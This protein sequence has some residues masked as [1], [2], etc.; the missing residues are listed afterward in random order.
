MAEDSIG[1]AWPTA[2]KRKISIVGQV[3]HT[4][5]KS[6]VSESPIELSQS[7]E[8]GG[9]S[10]SLQGCPLSPLTRVALVIPDDWKRD[11]D[12]GFSDAMPSSDEEISEEEEG[13][14]PGGVLVDFL[15]RGCSIRKKRAGSQHSPTN[16]ARFN[17]QPSLQGRC[18]SRNL[19]DALA[20]HYSVAQKLIGQH[21]TL[22]PNDFHEA[23]ER[24]NYERLFST[25]MEDFIRF[26]KVNGAAEWKVNPRTLLRQRAFEIA[27]YLN[28]AKC[29]Y[30]EINQQLL[31]QSVRRFV[32]TNQTKENAQERYG[33]T[34]QVWSQLHEGARKVEVPAVK[35]PF[36]DDLRRRL[37]GEQDKGLR[38]KS[39]GSV[40]RCLSNIRSRP[41]SAAASDSG[42]CEM[43]KENSLLQDLDWKRRSCRSKASVGSWDWAHGSSLH[44]QK[45]SRH[46]RPA[47]LTQ[48][49]IPAKEEECQYNEH[50]SVSL[51]DADD[52]ELKKVAAD[53]EDTSLE[54]GPVGKIFLSQSIMSIAD[55]PANRDPS[56]S[57]TSWNSKINK[58]SSLPNLRSLSTTTAFSNHVL[59]GKQV[60]GKRPNS[61]SSSRREKHCSQLQ[62]PVASAVSVPW[63]SRSPAP[64]LRMEDT[65]CKQY[66]RACLQNNT[67]PRPYPFITGHSLKLNAA[68]HVLSDKDLLDMTVALEGMHLEDIDLSD[69]TSLTE[70]SLLKFLSALSDGPTSSSLLRLSLKR[71]SHASKYSVLTKIIDLV[72]DDAGVQN[73]QHLDLTHVLMGLRCHLPFAKAVRDHQHLTSLNL[74]N[75]G[76]G[77][78]QG[79][80]AKEF[81]YNLLGSQSVKVLDL[82]WNS[83]TQDFFSQIGERH[84]EMQKLRRLSLSNCTTAPARAQ[85]A[86]SIG[87]FLQHL[88]RDAVL[89]FLDISLNHIDFRSAL[90]LE[91]AVM[92]CKKLTEINVAHNPLGVVGM[93]SFLRLLC[94]D[95]S[96]LMS[97][98]CHD[99]SSGLTKDERDGLQ[100]FRASDPGGRYCLEL[101]RPYHRAMLRMLYKT[102]DMFAVPIAEAFS[103]IAY[104]LP[105]WVHGEKDD[106]GIWIVPT[107]GKLNVTFSIDQAMQKQMQGVPPDDFDKY[108]QKYFGLMKI[109]PSFRKVIP[110]F[111]Q[112]QSLRGSNVE[113]IVMLDAMA[114]DFSLSY[115][116]IHQM[117]K[118]DLAKDVIIQRLFACVE[119]GDAPRYLTLG[120]NSKLSGFTR[121]MR[122]MSSLLAFNVHNPNG[123]YKLNL[124]QHSDHAVA[125]RLLLLDRWESSLC[126]GKGLYD[127]TQRGNWSVIRNETYSNENINIRGMVDWHLPE[128]DILEFDYSSHRRPPATAIALDDITHSNIMLAIQQAASSTQ[129]QITA[130]RMSSHVI[131]LS[132]KQVRL[133][134]GAY[135]DQSSYVELIVIFITRIMDIYNEKVF[136]VRIEDEALLDQMRRRIG[137]V[138][139]WPF[140]QPEQSHFFL[141]FCE[142][143]H[144]IV[145]NMLVI[146]S[147]KED[148]RN[149]HNPKLCNGKGEQVI[150]TSGVPRGWEKLGDIPTEGTLS[151]SYGCAPENKSLPRRKQLLET[152]GHWSVFIEPKDVMWWASLKDVPADVL[153]FLEF[154]IPRYEKMEM[155]FKAIDGH[156]G[157]GQIMLREFEDV[158]RAGGSL[159]CKKFQEPKHLEMER[160]RS[161]FRWLDPSGEGQVSIDEFMIFDQMLNE[162]TLSIEEFVEFCVRTFGSALEDAYQFL[163]GDGS[164]EIDRDEWQSACTQIGYLGPVDAIFNFCDKDEEGSISLDEFLNLEKFKKK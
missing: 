75:T 65:S 133:L 49:V 124:S 161:V 97:F 104:S 154:L 81:I 163:D 140:I 132:A 96:G 102:C 111:A 117:T 100:T 127:T 160:I 17:E 114:K 157:N 153:A 20:E 101:D 78:N 137:H 129:G 131:F 69:N 134:F 103:H 121:C 106:R 139:L 107:E 143:E 58:C 14:V 4:R 98:Q 141:N 151:V 84:I 29:L 89:E 130:L 52:D 64:V 9:P 36:K 123:H 71:C 43:R 142:R 19:Q 62:L 50:W 31:V 34:Q 1:T 6:I 113:Q 77:I 18:K 105:R 116:Q 26:W 16:K 112:W 7:P 48:Y 63:Q 147:G 125:E 12:D 95:S 145:A 5:R 53:F 120:L 126:Q 82:G 28:Q 91:D 70:K 45:I 162:V 159:G 41:Q 68:G 118:C 22:D 54:C 51:F 146:L 33:R 92:N 83:M 27:K 155:A 86:T 79:P 46:A 122:H 164:G 144:R 108:L 152:Y 21:S 24:I 38:P 115:A 3:V 42:G 40:A 110:L 109:V 85:E 93:R 158:V 44:S 10:R 15:Q 88:A 73:L 74:S 99:S 30:C 135:K 149:L 59:R 23:L 87:Y 57:P 156:D 128:Y 2:I 60:V 8:S 80:E 119:G 67:I 37:F 94:R 47:R 55:R 32:E 150:L 148:T 25:I 56:E 136:R 72:G 90:V 138:A 13:G 76:L 11:G 66:L 35:A 39:A 61:S